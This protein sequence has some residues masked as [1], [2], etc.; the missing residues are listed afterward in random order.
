MD[1]LAGFLKFMVVKMSMEKKDKIIK[2]ISDGNLT[3]AIE[4]CGTD[5][6][7]LFNMQNY[8]KEK[9]KVRDRLVIVKRILE[10]DPQNPN[11]HEKCGSLYVNLK[12][13]SDAEYEFNQ[14]LKIYKDDNIKRAEV[15]TYLADLLKKLERFEEAQR[16]YKKAIKE[17]LT[18]VVARKHLGDLLLKLG[19]YKEAELEYKEILKID[20]N[21]YNTQFH[22][23]I[24]LF[25]MKRY[26]ESKMAYENA[27]SQWRINNFL[28]SWDEIPRNDS[29][30]LIEFL[31]QKYSI[32]WVKTA[33]IEKIDNDKT[34]KVSVGKYYLSLSLNNEKSKVNLR[35][36]DGITDDFIAMKENGTLNIYKNKEKELAE[37]FDHLGKALVKL[38]RYCEAYEKYN[39]AIDLNQ[40]HAGA[41]NNLGV[42][43]KELGDEEKDEK[44][45]A[46][47]YEMALKKFEKASQ[48]NSSYAI[49]YNNR[50]IV[51]RD[52]KRISEAKES[53]EKGIIEDPNIADA[54]IN[55]GV[56][57]AEELGKPDKAT[58]EFENAL[59]I[60]PGNPKAI[61]NLSLAKS[62]KKSVEIDWWQGSKTKKIGENI[63]FLILIILI[64]T[65]AYSLLLPGLY[66]SKSTIETNTTVGLFGNTTITTL[67]NNV[68][69]F[70]QTT[71]LIGIVI[72]ILFLPQIKKLK[73]APT[74]VEFEKESPKEIE[75]ELEE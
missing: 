24:V 13:Y 4:E 51:L 9:N 19:R 50:G 15:R 32:D 39:T 56:L 70:E 59:R 75:S 64:L 14:A 49:I 6:L 57:Y 31:K 74:G 67:N 33:K 29:V 72:L 10:I 55:L 28:F 62:S 44:R 27:L 25:Q 20:P 65:A 37:V 71:I 40:Y 52:L 17:D 12:K 1:D 7:C 18:K 63:I 43:L 21:Y 11:A 41:Y 5:I 16:Q 3:E 58:E 73:I 26:E 69:P 22:L 2:L 60:E 47:L 42:L 66:G 68:I 53:F 38:K 30:R 46:K 61:I 54:Y 36:D 48:I 45:K 23:G 8:L 35:I 34:I